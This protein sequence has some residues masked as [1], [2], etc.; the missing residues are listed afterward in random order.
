MR[1]KIIHRP[2]A[3]NEVAQ[4]LRLRHVLDD[5]GMA[6][7]TG[8]AE[9]R[10]CLF[11]LR[12]AVDD[13]GVIRR[14]ELVRT[15]PHLLHEWAGG[16]V[17]RDVHPNRFKLRFDFQ[18]GSKCRDQHHIV[19]PQFAQRREGIAL[20]VLQ[21]SNALG[22]QVC[23]YLRIVNHLAKQK[24]ALSGVLLQ[25]AVGD[26]NRVFDPETKPKMPRHHEPNGAEVKHGG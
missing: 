7:P 1:P 24:D 15:L 5:Q 17:R 10:P 6:R 13:D 26:F 21:K 14:C 9:G 23:I 11:M 3:F 4:H 19:R 18:R 8:V 22:R 25:G 20:G 16:V 12:F 2:L